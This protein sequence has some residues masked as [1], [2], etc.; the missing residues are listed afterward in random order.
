[1]SRSVVVF[2]KT[3]SIKYSSSLPALTSVPCG[4]PAGAVASAGGSAMGPIRAGLPTLS[5]LLKLLGTQQPTCTAFFCVFTFLYPG[6]LFVS[7]DATCVSLIHRERKVT[8]ISR[9]LCS[10]FSLSVKCLVKI[11]AACSLFPN[12]GWRYVSHNGST[13][14]SNQLSYC[15]QW[16]ESL[17]IACDFPLPYEKS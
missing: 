15:C 8:P 16:S 13:S 11:S 2:S 4:S 7:F 12:P 3:A 5:T 14:W 17:T 6:A 9:R 10:H 1:M